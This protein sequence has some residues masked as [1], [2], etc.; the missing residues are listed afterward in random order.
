MTVAAVT[1]DLVWPS[2]VV[3]ARF[4]LGQCYF[5]SGY[6]LLAWFYVPVAVSVVGNVAM[7]VTVIVV[8]WRTTQ[9]TRSARDG[10]SS[11]KQLIVTSLKIT[12]IFGVSWLL[13]IT[14]ALVNNEVFSDVSG[15][16]NSLQGLFVSL[17]FVV[18]LRTIRA[19]K[20]RWSEVMWS[21][22][23]TYST[24]SRS[25]RKTMN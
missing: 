25:I 15:I 6:A 19:V 24:N 12:A 23:E 2:S 1:V 18:N 10:H 13:G 5:N 17:S 9:Q 7:S 20:S 4:G 16:I 8:I 22:N 14:A 21:K 11:R 3:S